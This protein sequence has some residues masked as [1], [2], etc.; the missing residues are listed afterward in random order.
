MLATQL[1]SNQ[2]WKHQNIQHLDDKTNLEVADSESDTGNQLVLGHSSSSQD[3]ILRVSADYLGDSLP[4][5]KLR[6]R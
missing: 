4:F 6:E 1:P 5:M 3:E 2:R